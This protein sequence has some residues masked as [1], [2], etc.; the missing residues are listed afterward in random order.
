MLPY[1]HQSIDDADIDVVERVLRGDWLTTGPAVAEFEEALTRV[2]EAAGVVTTTSGTA[3]LH[4]AYLALDL[5]PGDEVIATPLTFIATTSTASMCGAVIRFAD[6]C[7]DTGTIDPQAVEA[8]LTDRTRVIAG[9]DYAGHPIDAPALGQLARKAGA[10]LLE[11]AAHSIGA[12]LDGQ[13][14]GSLADVTTFSFFPTKN[15]TTGEGGAVAAVDHAFV[16]RVRRVHNIGLIRAHGELR[17]QDLGPWHQEVHSFGL[18]YRLNDLSCALGLSQLARLG[19]F[20][21]RR[22]EIKARYDAALGDLDGVNVPVERAGAA[23]AWH[24]YPLR[25]PAERRRALFEYLRHHQIGVQVNYV[26]VY[27]HPVYEDLGHR[28]GECPRAEEY[29][30][31]EVSLPMFPDLTD[32][33]VDRVIELIRCFFGR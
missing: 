30:S 15:M 19:G 22:A 24:L 10:V 5:R 28:R 13:P 4:A 29:Y 21:R 3:A 32:A 17:H 8:L 6:V 25:V 31:R 2:T 7:P 9:V 20:V 12:T 14:V 11:D 33:D 1:G 23:A 18:N 16:E 27:W 26:P